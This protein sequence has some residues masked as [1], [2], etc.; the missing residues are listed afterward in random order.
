MNSHLGE[1]NGVLLQQLRE[2]SRSCFLDHVYGVIDCQKAACCLDAVNFITSFVFHTGNLV[3]HQRPMEV[4]LK[5]SVQSMASH[6]VRTKQLEPDCERVDGF[7][8]L[9]FVLSF[10]ATLSLN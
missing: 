1:G 6:W 5:Q 3:Q 10:G 4:R 8:M 7:V 2:V 9:L